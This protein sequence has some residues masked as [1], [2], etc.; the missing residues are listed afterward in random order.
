MAFDPRLKTPSNLVIGGPSKAGKSHFVFRMIRE[1]RDLFRGTPFERVVYCYGEWQK[2]FQALQDQEGV[3]FLEGL[4]ED[5][6]EP[7]GGKPG[8][9]ILDDLM[10]ESANNKDVEKLFTRG[11]HHRQLTTVLLTQNLFQKGQRTQ[12]L[13]AHYVVAFK[14][15]RDRAQMG[16]LF[17]QAFPKQL[18]FVEEAFKDATSR[19]YGYLLFDFET[20]TPDGLRLRTNI[21]PSDPGPQIVYLDKQEA[22]PM[23][24]SSPTLTTGT[25]TNR[26]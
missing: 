22:W 3:V 26:S 1:R 7:F 5:L 20:D 4:P 12:M 16:F 14:N 6:Y 19:E 11:T 24:L 25:P 15:P 23:H 17:R 21:F 8:M 9:L 2:E 18:K 10:T 13:N